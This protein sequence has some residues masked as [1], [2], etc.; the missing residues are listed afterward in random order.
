MHNDNASAHTSAQTS[1]LLT[2]QSIELVGAPNRT[3]LAPNDFFL[4]P[5]IKIKM[6]GQR[7]SS[8]E[9]TVEAIKNHALKMSQSEWDKCLDN[10]FKRMQKL[11]NLAEEHFEE[12]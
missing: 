1:A 7:F 3:D 4:F 11:I 10:W 8:R 2:G 12:Q 5:H 9:G 6:R